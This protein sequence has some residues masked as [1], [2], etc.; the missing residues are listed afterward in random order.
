MECN[1][2]RSED[3]QG[4]R[5]TQ[6]RDAGSMLPT[7]VDARMKHGGW[8]FL[9]GVAQCRRSPGVSRVERAGLQFEHEE[10]GIMQLKGDEDELRCSLGADVCD[11]VLMEKHKC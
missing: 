5:G 11:Q 1:E 2:L 10:L 8:P 6:A 9:C 3:I 7:M 4:E